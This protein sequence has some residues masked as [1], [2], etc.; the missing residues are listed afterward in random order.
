LKFLFD[1]NLP[2]SLARGIGELSKFDPV[3]EQVIPLKDKFAANTPDLE[4]LRALAIEGGWIVVSIDRFKK[5]TAERE[6]LR[7]QGLTVF[8]LDRQWS[9]PYWLQSAQLVLWWPKI[10][11]EAKLTSKTVLRVPWRHG[12]KSTFDRVRV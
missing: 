12:G 2:P 1:N 6:M 7:R 11:D 3:V 4:W 5:S 10:V 9:K 8:V